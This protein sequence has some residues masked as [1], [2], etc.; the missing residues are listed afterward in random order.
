[1]ELGGLELTW[2]DGLRVPI[3]PHGFWVSRGT[4]RD[5]GSTSHQERRSQGSVSV[6][7]DGF[8]LATP[9]LSAGPSLADGGR[10]HTFRSTAFRR[11][12]CF[13]TSHLC[14]PNSP[15]SVPKS[16]PN[17][18]NTRSKK[19]ATGPD[20]R[21]SCRQLTGRI[22]AVVATLVVNELVRVAYRVVGPVFASPVLCGVGC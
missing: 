18:A 13:T 5:P 1:M 19:L 6:E 20:C 21:R 14:G 2:S 10:S 22:S 8:K 15:R 16:V 11:P 3:W 12:V 7:G 17:T 9:G 4:R